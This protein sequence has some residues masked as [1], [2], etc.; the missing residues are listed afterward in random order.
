MAPQI[1]KSNQGKKYL[2][3]METLFTLNADIAEK[4]ERLYDS[5]NKLNRG[6]APERM[7]VRPEVADSSDLEDDDNQSI[8]EAF[9]GLPDDDQEPE[10]EPEVEAEADAE[11]APEPE[12]EAEGNVEPGPEPEPEVEAE[13]DAEPAPAS[14]QASESTPQPEFFNHERNQTPRYPRYPHNQQARFEEDEK[15][16]SPQDSQAWEQNERDGP[17]PET[18]RDT[19][20]SR[21]DFSSRG[22]EDFPSRG[23]QEGSQDFPSRDYQGGRPNFSFGGREDFPSRDYQG[24]RPDFSSRGREDFPSRGYQGG[25]SDFSSRGRP[26]FSSRGREDFPSRGYQGGRSFESR[27]SARNN[28]STSS[29]RQGPGDRQPRR[30]APSDRQGP[31][32]WAPEDRQALVALEPSFPVGLIPESSSIQ[33]L[34]KMSQEAQKSALFAVIMSDKAIPEFVKREEYKNLVSVK[35]TAAIKFFGDRM[36][37]YI[38]ASGKDFNMDTINSVITNTLRNYS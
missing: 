7:T 31:G 37:T 15:W 12:V 5:I 20:T 30:S 33:G 19:S 29:C 16:G 3:L 14:E 8:L 13:A 28:G 24:G 4:T 38:D 27:S 22:R 25:R 2:G 21:P 10:D 32:K 36:R 17:A 11:P 18:M 9:N 23:Y 35:R 26:D 6:G 34:A 1:L